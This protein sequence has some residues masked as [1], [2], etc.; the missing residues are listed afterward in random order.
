MH[1]V[2]LRSHAFIPMLCP[3]KSLLE[4]SRYF[5]IFKKVNYII[6]YA[7]ELI[8]NLFLSVFF[9]VEEAV[10]FSAVKNQTSPLA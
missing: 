8:T 7:E 9:Y 4:V 5:Y 6:L 3:F 1:V 2:S 10:L